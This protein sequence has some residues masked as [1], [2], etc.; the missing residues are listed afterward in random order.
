MPRFD[1]TGPRGGGSQT[2]RGQ[3]KC[4]NANI[5]NVGLGR[6]TG[7]GQ[8]RGLGRDFG[9]NRILDSQD[10]VAEL[11]TYK[12]KLEAEIAELEKQIK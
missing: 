1:G 8:G 7:R 4:Q 2:G 12:S 5:E 6:G 11:K 9:C 3:G 10:R